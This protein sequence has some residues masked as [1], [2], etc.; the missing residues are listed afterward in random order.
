MY[1]PNNNYQK[2]EMPV[3]MQGIFLGFVLSYHVLSCPVAFSIFRFF[4]VA[5]YDYQPSPSREQQIGAAEQ[6]C[7]AYYNNYN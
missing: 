1:Y 7:Q 2:S 4:H 6:G 5:A 3:N